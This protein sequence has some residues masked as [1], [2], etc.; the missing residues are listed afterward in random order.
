MDTPEAA[1]GTG[2]SFDGRS[3]PASPTASEHERRRARPWSMARALHTTV[4]RTPRIM[5]QRRPPLLVLAGFAVAVLAVLVLVIWVLPSLLTE[6]PRISKPADRHQAIT[7]TRTG[8]ALVLTALGAVG[9]LA[10]TARTYWLGQETYRLS[11]EGHITDRYS[12][13]VEQ[14]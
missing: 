13:A 3:R 11:R 14:L 8:L 4:V 6:H 9:G 1:S 10:F 5:R 2:A 12:K 7:N